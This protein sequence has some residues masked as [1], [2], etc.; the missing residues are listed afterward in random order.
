M[1]V[2]RVFYLIAPDMQSPQLLS[3]REFSRRDLQRL[4]NCESLDGTG[5]NDGVH[6][7]V[8]DNASYEKNKA[9]NS[10]ATRYLGKAFP[11]FMPGHIIRGAVVIVPTDAIV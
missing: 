11:K 3:Q 8:G 7:M 10:L 5:M 6:T 4:C 2:E 1:P 9:I